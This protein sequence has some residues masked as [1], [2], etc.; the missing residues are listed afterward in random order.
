M[1]SDERRDDELDPALT[2]E[3]RAA[4]FPRNRAGLWLT[5]ALLLG[6]GAAAW[7]ASRTVFA[8]LWR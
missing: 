7:W 6:L 4:M 5:L 2:D 8:A 1:A 3:L